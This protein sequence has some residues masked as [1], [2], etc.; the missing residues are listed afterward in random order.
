[1][2]NYITFQLFQIINIYARSSIFFFK[3]TFKKPTR[4][5][6]CG[7]WENSGDLLVFLFYFGVKYLLE[8]A[9]FLEKIKGSIRN[10]IYGFLMPMIINFTFT[11]TGSVNKLNAFLVINDVHIISKN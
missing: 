4:N 9:S 1:M 10:V 8:I 2:Y 7:F 3:Q 11:M 6:T 5:V